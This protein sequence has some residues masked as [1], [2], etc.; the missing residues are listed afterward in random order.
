[1]DGQEDWVELEGSP[2][3][4]GVAEELR[5]SSGPAAAIVTLI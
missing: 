4:R 3:S 5:T 1:M 2:L